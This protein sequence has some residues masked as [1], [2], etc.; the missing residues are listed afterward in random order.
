MSYDRFFTLKKYC[1]L[2]TRLRAK[3]LL[4]KAVH[5]KEVLQRA[6]TRHD[7]LPIGRDIDALF[8]K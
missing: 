8:S 6:G 2:R 7:C 4:Y 5:R 3:R 1:S